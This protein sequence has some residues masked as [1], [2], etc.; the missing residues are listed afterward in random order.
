MILNAWSYSSL[1]HNVE[2]PSEPAGNYKDILRDGGSVVVVT[3]VDGSEHHELL[4]RTGMDSYEV[5][6]YVKE[7]PC[8]VFEEPD[9]SEDIRSEYR[10][11]S[12]DDT[13]DC[14]RFEVEDY[15]DDELNAEDERR[16]RSMLHEKR[17]EGVVKVGE[18]AELHIYRN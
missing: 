13:I 17:A 11:D 4:Q 2:D 12:V 7:P 8:Q 9:V 3:E 10:F 18:R 6:R 5:D 14:I 16:L 15:G 1:S